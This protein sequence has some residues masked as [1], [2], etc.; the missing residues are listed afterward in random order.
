MLNNMT[1]MYTTQ[2]DTLKSRGTA[3]DYDNRILDLVGQ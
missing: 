2:I 1:K 3:I